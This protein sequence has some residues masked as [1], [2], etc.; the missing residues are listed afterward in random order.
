MTGMEES[1]FDVTTDSPEQTMDQGLKMAGLLAP[2]DVV[3]LKGD[4]GAGKTHFTKG[5]AEYFGVKPENVS[6]PTYALVQEY[7]GNGI[8]I[9]H[10]D[11][12]RLNSVDEALHIGLDEILDGDGIYVV[13]W[14]ERISE[15]LPAQ[16]WNVEIAHQGDNQRRITAFRVS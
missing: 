16:Y 11:A 4:L 15:L 12:Y 14:P 2:G 5:L 6:S 13:E 8:T 7:M 9:F 3:C 1:I 10:I